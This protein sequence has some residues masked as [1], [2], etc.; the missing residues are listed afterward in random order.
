MKGACGRLF[1]GQDGFAFRL[2]SRSNE[3]HCMD[4]RGLQSVYIRC[5]M[6][7]ALQSKWACGWFVFMVKR[8]LQ[9]VNVVL[10]TLQSK[11]NSARFCALCA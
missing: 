6:G 10:K 7:H 2:C 9:S 11:T 1:P 5:P 8:G 4:K 3:S